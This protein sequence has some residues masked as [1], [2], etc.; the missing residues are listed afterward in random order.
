M[1]RPDLAERVLRLYADAETLARDLIAAR[2]AAAPIDKP[3]FRR[4]QRAVEHA[5]RFLKGAGL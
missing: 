2:D 1:T 4:A 3:D 5:A